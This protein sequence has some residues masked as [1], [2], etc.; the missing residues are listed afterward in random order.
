MIMLDF[1]IEQR[2]SLQREI[3]KLIN[4]RFDYPEQLNGLSNGAI[5][6]WEKSNQII[7]LELIQSLK[8]VAESLFV[9]STRSQES[10]S[11]QNTNIH[12]LNQ[13]IINLKQIVM[14]N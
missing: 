13:N 8:N 12:E 6:L 14:K 7:H 1:D 9:L 5:D 3:L 2:M 11:L 4:Q 10:I